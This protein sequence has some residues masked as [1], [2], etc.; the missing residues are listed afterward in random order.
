MDKYEFN[1][2]SSFD[3]EDGNSI[4]LRSTLVLNPEIQNLKI[5]AVDA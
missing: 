1:S 3:P 5:T 2:W 4:F